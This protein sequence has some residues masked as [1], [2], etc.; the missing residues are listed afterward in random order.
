MSPPD[1]SPM[2][3][4]VSERQALQLRAALAAWMAEVRLRLHLAKTKIAYCKNGDRRGCHE[5]TSFDFLGYQ[6]CQRSVLNTNGVLFTAFGP[7]ISPQALKKISRDVHNWRIH[8]RMRHEL[9]ELAEQVSPPQRLDDLLP[10][11]TGRNCVPSSSTSTATWC[12]GP[13][14]VPTA[15]GRHPTSPKLRKLEEI[16]KAAFHYA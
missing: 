6:F 12:M 9:H 4:W 8:T 14:H 15:A 1:Y 5:Q 11:S 13:Q 3:H 16:D 2:V 10:G 7:A